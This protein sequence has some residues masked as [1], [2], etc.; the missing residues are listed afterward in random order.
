MHDLVKQLRTIAVINAPNLEARLEMMARFGRFF[1][2]QI[3]DTYGG[4]FARE[5]EVHFLDTADGKKLRLT[6]Y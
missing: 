3:F 6:R 4:L 5:P 1:A 2:G